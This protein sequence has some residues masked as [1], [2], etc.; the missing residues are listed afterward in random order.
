MVPYLC[1]TYTIAIYIIY[2]PF[3]LPGQYGV[4]IKRARTEDEYFNSDDEAEEAPAYQPKEGSP[5]PGNTRQ[6]HFIHNFSLLNNIII[7]IFSPTYSGFGGFFPGFYVIYFFIYFII[8]N[9]N[10]TQDSYLKS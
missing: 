2:T 4:A 7:I 6:Y 3:L 5:G 9:R 8:I 10:L 1:L